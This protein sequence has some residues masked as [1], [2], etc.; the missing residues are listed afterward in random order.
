MTFELLGEYDS[1]GED[2]E[3]TLSLGDEPFDGVFV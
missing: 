2:A 3:I 1:A